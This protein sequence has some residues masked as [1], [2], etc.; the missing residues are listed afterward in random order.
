MYMSTC[1]VEVVGSKDKVLV[2][3]W[4]IRGQGMAGEKLWV[5]AATRRT[6]RL[7]EAEINCVRV[8]ERRWMRF[9]IFPLI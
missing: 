8:K 3:G 7:E 2:R 5:V 1:E 9:R 4:K 6:R